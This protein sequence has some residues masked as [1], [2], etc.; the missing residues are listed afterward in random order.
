MSVGDIFLTEYQLPK[1][2]TLPVFFLPF[3]AFITERIQ[4]YC[5]KSFCLQICRIFLHNAIVRSSPIYLQ[6]LLNGSSI[7]RVA[8][9][10]HKEH[11]FM[12]WGDTM[13]RTEFYSFSF[14]LHAQ[15][16]VRNF[17]KKLVKHSKCA[18]GYS[19]LCTMILKV[20]PRSYI[21]PPRWHFFSIFHVNWCSTYGRHI[22][23]YSENERER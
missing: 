20:A 13:Q 18:M 19:Y 5:S 23:T 11:V 9:L 17:S 12:V 4:P 16:L 22:A 2:H 10:L 8:F 3:W 14:S 7:P 15:T 1:F 6:W 21:K